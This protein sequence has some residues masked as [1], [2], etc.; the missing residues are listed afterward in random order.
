MVYGFGA[1]MKS[2]KDCEAPLYYGFDV[3]SA[4]KIIEGFI[5]SEETEALSHFSTQLLETLREIEQEVIKQ[6][7]KI[8]YSAGDNI[9]FYGK[10]D[11]SWCQEILHSF[12]QKT[13]Y[14]ASIGIGKTVT[15]FYLALRLAKSKGGGL[16]IHY[17]APMPVTELV[18]I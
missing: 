15:E 16:A 10:F 18:D 5:F 2:T 3:D 13:G 1:A 12:K 17:Q 8:I 11:E 6:E 14:S 9:L 4:K 7:G